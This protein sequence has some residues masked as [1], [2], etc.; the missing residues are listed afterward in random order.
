MKRFLR[1]KLLTVV[2]LSGC[3][4][5][6]FQSDEGGIKVALIA[7]SDRKGEAQITEAWEHVLQ[8][9]GIP[10]VRLTPAQLVSY[11]PERLARLH[12]AL[13]FPDHRAD[14]LPQPVSWL[15][16]SYIQ[17]GGKALICFD[18]GMKDIRG[19]YRQRFLFDSVTGIRLASYERV[20]EGLFTKEAIRFT[21]ELA[22][23]IPPG[24]RDSSGRLSNYGYGVVRYPMVAVGSTEAGVEIL[25][26]TAG[27]AE[28]RP[29]ITRKKLGLGTVVFV[30]PPLGYL[31]AYSDDFPLR[32]VVKW[33]VLDE[34]RMPRL[35][36]T[37]RGVGGMVFNLHID[38]GAHL[39]P[40]RRLLRDNAFQDALR[41]SIHFTAGPDTYKVGDG[42]GFR[43][44]DPENGGALASRLRRFGRF[45]SHGGWVHEY[46][47]DLVA[48]NARAEVLDLIDRN[49]ASV[50][51]AAG[52]AV[53]EYSAPNGI[54]PQWI[55]SSLERHGVNSYYYTG[56]SGSS[57]N[58]TFLSGLQSSEVMWAFPVSPLGEFASFQ[59]F[60]FN[61]LPE[62]T[63]SAWLTQIA[64]FVETEQTIR[65]VY[66]HPN[67][68]LFY[69]DAFLSFEQSLLLGVRE[70]R[71]TV[72]SMSEY[73]DFL[74]KFERATL[75]V[76]RLTD[77]WELHIANPDQ[78][79]EIACS[80]PRPH[81]GGRPAVSGD[82]EGFRVGP[83][84]VTVNLKNGLTKATVKVVFQ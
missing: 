61:G 33:F 23:R 39:E 30:N 4:G 64:D 7:R 51:K 57:P 44:D 73:A 26:E 28:P 17:A 24:K 66:G 12:P 45:G 81:R 22:R 1:F 20:G 27:P 6:N 58:R 84:R 21:P 78:L 14:R 13:I 67:D 29:T 59:E 5:D 38:S 48:K 72:R 50:N 25:A 10:F 54:H 65:L 69:E 71:L 42:A 36:P 8:E 32:L 60:S 41:M 56:D 47:A 76:R 52:Y 63:V 11:R 74:T 19:A 43:L 35:I 82:A 79:S 70:G 18:A 83:D 77:G 31:K 3:Q 80:V 49:F 55:N 37:P 62:T 68:L 15:V 2:L 34:V 9:E 40:L 53:S 46:F 16:E 75:E